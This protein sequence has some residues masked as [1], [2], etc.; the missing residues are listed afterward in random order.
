M[1]TGVCISSSDRVSFA[2]SHTN[3]VCIGELSKPVHR[4]HDGESCP[5]GEECI[6][7]SQAALDEPVG[8]PSAAPRPVR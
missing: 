2:L 4:V 3:L 7:Q 1:M 6:F 5:I 8:C